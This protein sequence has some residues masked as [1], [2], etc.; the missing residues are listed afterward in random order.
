M[1]NKFSERIVSAGGGGGGGLPNGGTTGQHLAK[2]SNID[3][4]V[5]WVDA[6][7][8]GTLGP[9]TINR[10]IFASGVSSIDSM[11]AAGTAGQV[12][13]SNGSG[14]PS[15]GAVN[16]ASEVSGNLSVSHLNSGTNANANTYWAGDGTWKTA[17]TQVT[18][19]PAGGTT[20]QHLAK[21]DNTDYN[22]IWEDPESSAPLGPFT[23]NGVVYANG[24]D[25]IS[26]LADLGDS[27]KVL[28]GNVSGVP[29]WGKVNLF[30]DVT[31]NLPVGNLNSGT[32]ASS[33]TFW[34]GD[35]T[36]GIAT[37][38]GVPDGGTTDQVLAKISNANQDVDW[39]TLPEFAAPLGPFTVN[40]IV[41]AD[42]TDTISNLSALGTS[43]TVLHGNAGGIP[44]WGAVSLVNDV[45]GNLPVAN[46]NSGT[47]AS[48][49]TYWRGDGTWAPATNNGVPDGGTTG[50]HLAKQSNT[51]QDVIW[52]DP[53]AGGT[54][55]P[56]G[57]TAGQHLAKIDSTDFNA[58][59]VDPEA[60]GG[61]PAGGSTDQVL[62]K[63]SD[64]DYDAVWSTPVLPSPPPGVNYAHNSHFHCNDPDIHSS[65]SITT[66]ADEFTSIAY[67]WFAHS[68]IDGVISVLGSA[69]D[70]DYIIIKR[71]EGFTD[72]GYVDLYQIFDTKDSL[73][74]QELPLHFTMRVRLP[75]SASFTMDVTT[76]LIIG[77]GTDESLIAFA[78]G[79]WDSSNTVA[80]H[81]DTAIDIWS[82]STV[83]LPDAWNFTQ[84]GMKIRLYFDQTT[85]TADDELWIHKAILTNL[86]D[87]LQVETK[88]ESTV[89]ADCKRYY[90]RQVLYLTT[91]YISIPI[92]M[93]AVPTVTITGL[94]VT[95]FDTAGTTK[96]FLIIKVVNS[97]DAGLHDVYL[98]AEL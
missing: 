16:L 98:N 52:V 48:G 68:E 24:T 4:D 64:D 86:Y 27:H 58:E 38:N 93:R 10:L 57:G 96:D 71:E 94:D 89:T 7:S 32:G 95:D 74:L 90:Q 40:G 30:T 5:V 88:S 55:I 11:A 36:W 73:I 12:L 80:S 20:G 39:V 47:G 53:E 51:N 75:P 46:L 65:V 41:F 59:W 9:F 22:V 62:T 19:I 21:L 81:V 33:S 26:N 49:S 60:G 54:G 29:T 23:I 87:D 85:S 91:G 34:R 92:T 50:Q 84:L 56:A 76:E 28:H 6:E 72:I 63:A 17:A 78:D 67:R 70:T 31:N 61:I 79:T 69:N 44:T 35:G 45:T 82:S 3:Q 66:V 42:S 43:V 1:F 8:G 77:Q 18:G 2:A 83:L 37:A 13:H 97:G 14:L 25:T 15:W